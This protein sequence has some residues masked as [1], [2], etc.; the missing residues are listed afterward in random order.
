MSKRRILAVALLLAALVGLVWL[1]RVLQ[2]EG[3]GPGPCV[4]TLEA[5][6]L[7]PRLFNFVG[8]GPG[9]GRLVNGDALDAKGGNVEQ[10]FKTSD[11][12]R[13]YLLR[14]ADGHPS[15][16]ALRGSSWSAHVRTSGYP[17]ICDLRAP[18]KALVVQ[19]GEKFAIDDASVEVA[20]L[21]VRTGGVLLVAGAVTL[22]T[23]FVL[24]E[25]G[26]LLQAGSRYAPSHRYDAGAKFSLVLTNGSGAYEELVSVASQYSSDVYAPGITADKAEYFGDFT[27]TL[28]HHLSNC[29]GKKSVCVG[30]NGNL[31]LAGD[32]GPE[33]E[34]RATWD[35][36]EV[37]DPNNTVDWFGPPQRLSVGSPL[38]RKSYPVT[39]IRLVE[40][41][42]KGA[43]ELL[44]DRRDA[45]AGYL[46]KWAPGSQLLITGCPEQYFT[47]QNPTGLL[48]VWVDND[49][50]P[51]RAANEGAN[52][53]LSQASSGLEVQRIASVNESTGVIYLADGL[54]FDH[55]ASASA[56]IERADGKKVQVDQ[57][58][59]VC[60]LTRNI[61]VTSELTAGASG[62]NVLSS[63][64]DFHTPGVVCNQPGPPD[65]ELDVTRCY[66]NLKAA[67]PYCGSMSLPP[68]EK[69]GGHWLF[70]SQG[71]SGCGAIHGGQCLFRYG[72]AVHVDA[73]EL[74]YMGT[75]G[76]F[77][78]IAQYALHFHMSG[79]AQSF[80]D[81]LPG[82]TGTKRAEPRESNVHN[83][84]IWLSLSR[85]VTLHGTLEASISNN[86]G[87]FCLG[88]G[89]FIEDGTE[90]R[91][92][93]EHNVGAYALPGVV[94]DYY[95]PVPLLPNV[96]SDFGP[97]ATFW[98]KN[99][100][101]CMARNVACASPAPVMGFWL[102]PQPISLLRG[103]STLL[104]GSELLGLPG[105][106]SA[107][108][109]CDD[110]IGLKA[111]GTSNANGKVV[112]F[113]GNTPCWVPDDFQFP[114]LDKK[115]KCNLYNKDNS[116]VPLWGF[117]E[118]VC[119]GMYMFLSVLPEQIA[120]G[121]VTVTLN[122][123]NCE[124]AT[125]GV[126]FGIGWQSQDNVARGQWM[127]VN[128]QNA[129]T[130]TIVSAYPESKWDENLSD[131]LTST[132][133]SSCATRSQV[134]TYALLP[135]VMSGC[136]GFGFSSFNAQ[137]GG[138]MW[139]HQGP[140]WLLNCAILQRSSR[141]AQ[142]MPHQT[143]SPKPLQGT[144]EDHPETQTF[145]SNFSSENSIG[146]STVYPVYY[147][148]LTNG[149]Y[150]PPP[151]PTLFA[152]SLSCFPKQ[153]WSWGHTEAECGTCLLNVFCDFGDTPLSSIMPAQIQ[154]GY[155]FQP[156]S[157]SVYEWGEA[158][159]WQAW[160][161]SSG[162][163][164]GKASGSVKPST[165][166]KF[167]YL[168]D[169]QQLR[170]LGGEPLANLVTGH[171]YTQ[172]ARATGDA[173]CKALTRVPGCFGQGGAA[174]KAPSTWDPSCSKL[175]CGGD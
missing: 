161:Y 57:P 55:D 69:V 109:A 103:P 120:A 97:M 74:K 105:L 99:N 45:P 89:Y 121:P 84:S 77:G 142:P 5:Q 67:S 72:S 171:F 131:P 48:P 18:D 96:S 56:P 30:F 173:V 23:T 108:N 136:L 127:P 44:Y 43:K 114:L 137:A 2:Y 58:L 91:N 132:E 9:P 3:R 22:R 76:N 111:H 168:C 88:S 65:I 21:V 117:M 160:E 102:V 20:G 59:H 147:N 130:D 126:V 106:A 166:A 155:G 4:Q 138:A 85:W 53:T 78:S 61:L 129:C 75:P 95:N 12:L 47:T 83:C 51:Q 19:A 60:L 172:Q 50:G 15:G 31:H 70:G 79:Y 125:R 37:S 124:A 113:R 164:L 10:G 119:Y 35:A 145:V 64:D 118:N 63:G 167:P 156:N 39:W 40:K 134:V 8:Q 151:N 36:K 68:P 41:A 28:S 141:D 139:F 27:G 1:W 93:F 90:M 157:I 26:G 7:D 158:G 73:V 148:F 52:A 33:L 140:A 6:L 135:F 62:C 98:M 38:L 25:S 110:T 133:K 169:V 16:E 159:E 46:S 146:Y 11:D 13:R 32:V 144:G 17:R 107:G 170:A 112:T 14:Y 92:V 116:V 80:L 94:N 81:Y 86:V 152:G 66:S 29:F 175:Y 42:A 71:V 101:N 143:C 24:V 162:G 165:V 54:R 154:W 128:G 104:L 150:N 174:P 115:T 82:T 123:Q 87:F 163:V 153:G 122:A 34:Y 100:M 49:D 149:A